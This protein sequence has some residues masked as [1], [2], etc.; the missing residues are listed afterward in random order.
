M[1]YS[2]HISTAASPNGSRIR[3]R[4]TG[5]CGECGAPLYAG[6]TAYYARDAKKAYCDEHAPAVLPLDVSDVPPFP[7]PRPPVA[8]RTRIK[9]VDPELPAA[10]KV[11]YAGSCS[12]CTKPLARGVDAFYIRAAKA[13]VCVEC[14]QLEVQLGLGVNT[15]G[16]GAERIAD[17]AGRRHAERLLA[18]YPMLGDRLLENAKPSSS[19]Q[20]WVRGADGERIVGKALDALVKQGRLE[21]LHDRVVPGTY[22]N[23]DHIV[24]GPRRITVIDAKH[25]RGA[26][27][28]IR[29][30]GGTRDLYVDGKPAGHLID[31]VR[32]Q[33]A[34]LSA[35]L[36]PEFEEVVEASL[37]FVGANHTALG[38]MGCRGAYCSSA[39]E[40]IAR[41]A[42]SGW[43]P[44]NPKLKF[45][46]EERAKI[47][48][49]IAV[50]FPP[51][52]S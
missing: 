29:K 33:Q 5:K 44:G 39:K 17:A 7:T 38:A 46:S 41:A 11:R 40:V 9:P 37:A 27:I 10:I 3:L 24:I 43:V 28:R 21:V 6:T 25:Y 13:M 31:G 16:A 23:F 4:F 22:A 49:R 8:E 12:A 36:G 35:V 50:A 47:R 51:N 52:R 1:P 42:F 26:M 14:T 32:T 19:A 48:D 34:K 2:D 45:E 20:A 30:V 15:P 18:A